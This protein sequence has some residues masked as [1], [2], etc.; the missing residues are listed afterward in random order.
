V[1]RLRLSIQDPLLPSRFLVLII[2]AK[3]LLTCKIA[4]IGSENLITGIDR[5]H[6]SAYRILGSYTSV[7]IH[8]LFSLIGLSNT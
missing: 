1:I 6:Y 5:D 3:S 8:W 4:F 7:V 2:S